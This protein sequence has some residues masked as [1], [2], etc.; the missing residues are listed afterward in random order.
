MQSYTAEQLAQFKLPNFPTTREGWRLRVLAEGW[1]CIEEKS[2]GRGGLKHS[3]IP[4]PE[5][6]ALIEQRLQGELPPAEPRPAKA[7][8][9][10]QPLPADNQ[11]ALA[12]RYY[13]VAD[14]GPVNESVEINAHLMWLCHDACLQVYGEA[15][16]RESVQVQID[17]AVDLYNLLLRL[18]AAKRANARSNPKDFYR[19]DAEDMGSQLKL[20]VQM[21]WVKTFPPPKIPP[22]A[23]SFS[24]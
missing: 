5:V 8:A 2:R 19:L 12:A 20:F 10:K 18:S 9:S 13:G 6:M 1:Q 7:P 4:P 16:A 3:Y 11:F 24:W 23:E 22:G 14:P 21:G 15:F 17:Y